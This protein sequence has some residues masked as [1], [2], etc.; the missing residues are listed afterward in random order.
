VRGRA[1]MIQIR[2]GTLPL[3][4]RGGGASLERMCM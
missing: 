1:A 4:P 2:A 3:P